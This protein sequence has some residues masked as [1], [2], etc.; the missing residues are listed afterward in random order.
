MNAELRSFFEDVIE[1]F[2]NHFKESHNKPFTTQTVDSCI[3]IYDL[4]LFYEPENIVEIGTNHG[5]S[6]ISILKALKN[7]GKNNAPFT[8]IDL[9]HKAWEEVGTIQKQ[10]VEDLSWES[11]ITITDDFNQVDPISV[12][13]GE[14]L[15]LFYDMHD[16]TG[17]WS[18]RLLTQWL[19]HMKNALIAIH[20]FSRVDDSYIVKS[21]EIQ[22]KTKMKY[23]NGQTYAGFLEVGR[24][25]KWANT[26][27]IKINNFNGGIYFFIKNGTVEI[28]E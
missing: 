10:L 5:A 15:F 11:V 26:N 8:S 21:T 6:T 14:K 20:D 17:P 7:L 23:L 4:C 28:L 2:S 9:S 19:P 25:I 12:N 22:P 24:I 27:R 16:H 13:L 1:N 3:S 18:L